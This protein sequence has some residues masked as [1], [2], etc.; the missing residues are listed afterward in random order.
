MSWSV[1]GAL[2]GEIFLINKSQ[3]HERPNRL[4]TECWA[5]EIIETAFTHVCLLSSSLLC[6]AE[7]ER[8]EPSCLESRPNNKRVSEGFFFSFVLHI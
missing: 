7:K 4:A 2:P 5:A 3:V 1:L 8:R 6:P